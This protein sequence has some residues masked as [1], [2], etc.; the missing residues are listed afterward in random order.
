MGHFNI[1]KSFTYSK[2]KLRWSH[3]GTLRKLRSGRKYRP[4]STKS[5]VHLVLKVDRRTLKKG[6][7]SPVGFTICRT[8][9]KLYARMFFVKIEQQAICGD[10]I[11]LL[12]R[13]SKRSLGQHFFRVVPGQ[14]SQQLKN[15]GLWVTGTRSI[16]L[17]RPF[18]RVVFGEKAHQ[19]AMN[20][21]RLNELEARGRLPYR[22]ERLRGLRPEEW[23]VLWDP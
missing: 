3:G 21:V 20:Y 6:L 17:H 15:L 4:L 23:Q 2:N 16:W 10:H 12:V 14:I 18:T 1:T 22:K 13:L 11:H 7:R 5:S 8:V 9:I 19:I